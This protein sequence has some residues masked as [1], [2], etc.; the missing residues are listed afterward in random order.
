M[1]LLL[2][3]QPKPKPRI[4]SLVFGGCFVI[5][6]LCFVIHLSFVLCYSFV[7]STLS[8][9]YFSLFPIPQSAFRILRRPRPIPNPFHLI[10]EHPATWTPLAIYSPRITVAFLS[11]KVLRCIKYSE[12]GR[13][14][15]LNS[16]AV[17][18]LISARN[19][20]WTDGRGVFFSCCI[21]AISPS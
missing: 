20:G 2:P 8:P 12:K 18:F 10:P 1:R 21:S 17:Q 5:W 11:Q 6:Y 19:N 3:P 4:S 16:E 14:E 13:V 15:S 9:V 7:I